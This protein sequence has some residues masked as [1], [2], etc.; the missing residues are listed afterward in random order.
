MSDV[1]IRRVMLKTEHENQKWLV[2]QGSVEGV[3]A[4]T[5][6][7]SIAMSAYVSRPAILDETRIKLIADVQEY[8]ANYLALQSLA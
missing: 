5:K 7:A 4:V 1:T 3:P 8:H 6:T 2:L